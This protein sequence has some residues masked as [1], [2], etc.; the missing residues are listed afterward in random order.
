MR[1]FYR[2][3]IQYAVEQRIKRQGQNYNREKIVKEMETT[4]PIAIFLLFQALIWLVDEL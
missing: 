4:N 2:K 3:L 1:N